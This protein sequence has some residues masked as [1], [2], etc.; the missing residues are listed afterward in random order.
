M[1]IPVI[2]KSS[3]GLFNKWDLHL[4]AYMMHGRLCAHSSNI[5]MAVPSDL[6]NRWFRSARDP[7]PKHGV[8]RWLYQDSVCSFHAVHYTEQNNTSPTQSPAVVSGGWARSFA[9]ATVA[10]AARSFASATVAPPAAPCSPALPWPISAAN[11][12]VQ[13][14][15]C[16][17]V[18]KTSGY[19]SALADQ[20]SKRH[21]TR[22]PW[23]IREKN[24]SMPVRLG[25]A[26]GKTNGCGSADGEVRKA[27]EHQPTKG[28]WVH[29]DPAV[30]VASGY[31]SAD[32]EVRKSRHTGTR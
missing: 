6:L 5:D 11:V 16:Q 10:P 27:P 28:G 18:R 2:K 29:P 32:A 15:L 3:R 25:Q 14:F 30:D 4:S 7:D 22:P 1:E 31:W 9:S 26:L 12:T 19:G 8:T 21:S 23:P 20:F 24:S 13:V 17:G